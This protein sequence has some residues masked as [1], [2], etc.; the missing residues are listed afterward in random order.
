MFLP[1]KVTLKPSRIMLLVL[2]T[3]H[4]LAALAV[5]LTGLSLVTKVGLWIAI[6]LSL[7]WQ[8]H[9]FYRFAAGKRIRE[10]RVDSRH[11]LWIGG[12]GKEPQQAE[13]K[14]AWL[15]PG[16]GVVAISSEGR[17]F[18]LAWMPDSADREELRR[19]R[20]WLRWRSTAS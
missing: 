3:L 13:L 15:G 2:A 9:A 19:W 4:G 17:T 14:N 10:L 11:G 18:H 20:V 16:Y 5:V 1:L 12:L 8:S 7:V 6:C